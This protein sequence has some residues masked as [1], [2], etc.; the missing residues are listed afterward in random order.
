[1]ILCSDILIILLDIAVR[2]VKHIIIVD[3][4]LIPDHTT[5]GFLDFL[6]PRSRILPS[7]KA[8]DLNDTVNI[9]NDAFN[10]DR[11]FIISETETELKEEAELAGTAERVFGTTFVQDAI[12]RCSCEE[13]WKY[14]PNGSFTPEGFYRR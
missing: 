7:V 13:V 3:L 12:R 1:M 6:L 14:L 10:N 4:V 8:N 11:R 9:R 5:Q 2:L